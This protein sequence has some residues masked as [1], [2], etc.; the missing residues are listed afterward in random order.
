MSSQ[1]HSWWYSAKYYLSLVHLGSLDD[2]CVVLSIQPGQEDGV[3][4]TVIN[5]SLAE[6]LPSI[7]D[8]LAMYVQAHP[9]LDHVQGMAAKYTRYLRG[10]CSFGS[11]LSKWIHLNQY[12]KCLHDFAA[13]EAVENVRILYNG[14]IHTET[15]RMRRAKR[16]ILEF[17]LQ[18]AL[19]E[20]DRPAGAIE[21][22]ENMFAVVD[23]IS[24]E[25]LY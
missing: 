24:V 10:K 19:F 4:L 12:I 2:A 3:L 25:L 21:A 16:L 20:E 8:Q 22:L 11:M 23:R 7:Q 17:Q 9:A 1:C 14:H 15:G 18:Y 13:I 6:L 5:S